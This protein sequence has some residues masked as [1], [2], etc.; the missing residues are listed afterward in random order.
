PVIIYIPI[1][2]RDNIKL[3]EKLLPNQLN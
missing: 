3:S 1:D 2:Y